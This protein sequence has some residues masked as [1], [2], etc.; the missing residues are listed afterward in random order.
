MNFI[1]WNKAYSLF[2]WTTFVLRIGVVTKT[3]TAAEARCLEKYSERGWRHVPHVLEVDDDP[4]KNPVRSERCVTDTFSWVVP[5][6]TSGVAKPDIPDHVIELSSWQC[7][8]SNGPGAELLPTLC[9]STQLFSNIFRHQYLCADECAKFVIKQIRGLQHV[10]RMKLI[11]KGANNGW[12]WP[13]AWYFPHVLPRPVGYS[14]WDDYFPKF[15]RLYLEKEK[16]QIKLQRQWDGRVGG[17][18]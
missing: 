6:D 11:P 4:L 3:I 14:Y 5:L 18:I 13:S 16:V 15:Y 2:P 1:T 12:H 9:T 10:E 17:V 8:T 7:W